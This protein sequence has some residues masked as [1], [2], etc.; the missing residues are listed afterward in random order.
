L[1]PKM[2]SRTHTALRFSHLPLLWSERAMR[3]V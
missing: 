1:T 2:V 3:R